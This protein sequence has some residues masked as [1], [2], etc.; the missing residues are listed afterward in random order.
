VLLGNRP[1]FVAMLVAASVV[2]GFCESIILALLAEIATALVDHRD[3]LTLSLG[4]VHVSASIDQLLLVGFVVA[5][6]R[7]AL[8]GALSYLPARI[9]ADTQAALQHR[10]FA[11]FTNA[12]WSVVAKDGEGTFQELATSQVIQASYGVV[13]ASTVLTSGFL[14]AV[15]V[16]SALVIQTVTAL[17]VIVAGFALFLIFRPLNDIGRRRAGALSAAQVTYAAGIHDAVST[18]EEAR[19]FGVGNVQLKQIDSLSAR[20]R[21][22]F[23]Q[24]QLLGRLVGGGYQS[25]V[26]LLLIGGLGIL[27][28][29]GTAGH[30]ASLGAVVLLLV[31]ASNFGQIVQTNYHLMQQSMPYLEGLLEAEDRYLNSHPV[32]GSRALDVIP[33]LAFHDV[34]YS[35]SPDRLV[36]QRLTFSI[37]PSEVIGI[38][39]PTGAG[40]ST[41]VQ[42]L[43]RL[44]GPRSGSY[45]VA[46]EPASA[47][48]PATWSERVSYVPQAPRLIHASVA[49]NIRFHRDLDHAAVE[50]AARQA[51]IH[52]EIT[53]WP[54]GYQTVIS[55]RAKAVSG[56]QRQRLC[57]AR[58]LAGDPL[59][60]V[61]DEPTSALDPRS[62]AL[63]QE[64][65]ATLKG[66][67]TI[68]VI[69]HRLSTLDLCDRVMVLRDGMI[70]AFGSAREVN[71]SNDFYKTAITLAYTQP[72]NPPHLPAGQR[73]SPRPIRRH[74]S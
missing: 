32:L 21:E 63:V 69:A 30:L 46:G 40:K 66:K 7:V 8:Q 1:F 24:T 20:E 71:E 22:Q 45:R 9:A 48:S 11:A 73:D 44:R 5:T 42:L 2:A 64:S 23:F 17:V 37:E 57:L 47:W 26:L 19:V 16:A 67:M 43:L 29:T 51:H 61:L 27:E 18:A 54:D 3:S 34:T 60:L 50:R 52:D 53:T 62:E 49:E 25:L 59:M 65:I 55:D 35:Y 13:Y 72:S 39:G 58:A 6:L 12:S 33:S 70:E 28:A 14:V 56:G 4:L 10:L 74:V 15:L 31:R 68:F 41:L 36:L 38:I